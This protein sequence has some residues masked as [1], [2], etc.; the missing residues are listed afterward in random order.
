MHCCVRVGAASAGTPDFEPIRHSLFCNVYVACLLLLLRDYVRLALTSC[1]CDAPVVEA[2]RVMT[3]L[4]LL[5][6]DTKDLEL[7]VQFGRARKH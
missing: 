1:R 6:A 7:I 3:L 2:W 5:S 4:L